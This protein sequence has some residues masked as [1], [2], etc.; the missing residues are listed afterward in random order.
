MNERSVVSGTQGLSGATGLAALAL[1]LLCN[2]MIWADEG[3]GVGTRAIP[4]PGIKTLRP[5]APGP[6]QEDNLQRQFPPPPR[7]GDLQPPTHAE[8]EQHCLKNQRCA[9]KLD[10]ARQGRRPAMPLPAA[11]APSPEDNSLKLAPSSG[12]RLPLPGPRSHIPNPAERFFSWINP[13]SI[14][15]AW[16]QTTFSAVLTPDNR[17]SAAAPGSGIFV[18]GGY[19][20]AGTPFFWMYNAYS[21]NQPNA[22]NKPY[23]YLFANLPSTGYY[24]IDIVS[25][26]SLTKFRHSSGQIL[27]TWDDRAGCGSTGVG[28]IT[29]CHHVTVDYYTAGNHFWYFWA[30]PTVLYT[31]FFSVTLK[32]YP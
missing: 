26:P 6:S 2:G 9:Q 16:G 23:V 13:F 27:E 19:L 22:E 12:Q 28:T 15:L 24:L 30:D 31:Y 5:A 17:W 25:S 1:V 3:G 32:S 29:P 18:S 20:A 7:P 11:T 8:M 21:T 14:D 10:Q 4:N